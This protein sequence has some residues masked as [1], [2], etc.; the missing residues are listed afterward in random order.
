M[1]ETGKK[2]L[3]SFQDHLSNN[4]EAYCKKHKIKSDI[5]NFI[6][7]LIDREIVPSATIRRYAIM[8]EFERLYP[9]HDYHKSNTVNTLSELFNLSTRHIWSLIKY[10]QRPDKRNKM[11]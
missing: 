5:N 11:D 4:Y 10:S 7:Y 8:Q 6:V 3:D 1:G 9:E 2:I